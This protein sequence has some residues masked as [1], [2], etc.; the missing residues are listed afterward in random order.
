MRNDDFAARHCDRLSCLNW[1]DWHWLRLVCRR[2]RRI[3]WLSG[4]SWLR[5][6]AWLWLRCISRLRL[7]NIW[8]LGLS[9]VSLCVTRLGCS[10]V[11]I[12]SEARLLGSVGIH[13]SG[14]LVALVASLDNSDGAA[15]SWWM[16]LTTTFSRTSATANAQ[17]DQSYDH[18]TN[19]HNNG[20]GPS[21]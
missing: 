13:G 16:M 11:N 21:S 7:R 2:S 17:D 5:S 12:R 9:W 3:L 20:N 4:I 18:E 14:R 6:V 1:L 15:R 8:L 19:N 10:R